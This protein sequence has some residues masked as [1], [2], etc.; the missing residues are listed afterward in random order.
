MKKE[1]NKST[2]RHKAGRTPKSDPAI[3]RYSI[4]FNEQQL[5]AFLTRFD[6]TGMKVKA[7]FI[8]ACIFNK[9]SP[10]YI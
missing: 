3:F 1:D 7:H 2:Q 4:S 10:Q 8:T 9:L 5:V 6:E